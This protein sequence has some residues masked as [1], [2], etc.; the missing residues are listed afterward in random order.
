MEMRVVIAVAVLAS[1]LLL[2]PAAIEQ[3]NA[4]HGGGGWRRRFRWGRP[5]LRQVICGQ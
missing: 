4:A 3:A 1:G 5:L 2:A